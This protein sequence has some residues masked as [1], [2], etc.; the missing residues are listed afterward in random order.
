M[1]DRDHPQDGYYSHRQGQ[2]LE[3][4]SKERHFSEIGWVVIIRRTA[5]AAAI[6]CIATICC[7]GVRLN[8]PM[9][10]AKIGRMER[11]MAN[12][13]VFDLKSC[14]ISCSKEF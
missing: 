5:T 9:Y 14:G 2:E 11:R 3:Q 1:V 6:N 12:Q 7:S 4:D 13:I 8:A 10:W